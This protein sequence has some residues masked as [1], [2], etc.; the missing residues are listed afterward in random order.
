MAATNQ[1]KCKCC[2][3]MF[4][5]R[6]ADRKRGWAQY[7][8]KSCKAKRQEASTGQYAAYRH[9]RE[10]IGS[11]DYDC[12]PYSEEAFHNPFL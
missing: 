8:S 6:T 3:D 4:T 2:G 5:A 7:C 1:Y 10:S 12:H 9:R 11:S